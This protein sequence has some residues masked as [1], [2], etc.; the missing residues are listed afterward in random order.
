MSIDNRVIKVCSNPSCDEV[1]HNCL[2]D[3]T[4]CRNCDYLLV[5]INRQTYMKKFI[6]YP[7]QTDYK[8]RKR[9]T[10]AIIY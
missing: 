10:K 4:R 3:E 8:T 1:A 9:L 5:E 7:H 2:K 6:G